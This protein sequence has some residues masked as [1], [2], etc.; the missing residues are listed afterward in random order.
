MKSTGV[1]RRVDELGRIVIPK[2]IRNNMRI[3]SGEGLEIFT[4]ED[5]LILKKFSPI[6]S[7]EVLAQ[8]YVD[9]IYKT[10][11]HNIIVTDMSKVIALAG[12]LKKKYMNEEISDFVERSIERRDN[13]VERQKKNFKIIENSEEFGYY[14]F[15]S[16]V[17]NGDC[18]GS[19]IIVSLD[20]PLLEVE[21]KMAVV[22]SRL[23]EGSFVL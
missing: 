23:L 13:F 5:M 17:V 16:I 11:K 18:L 7:L 22:L 10:I 15:C 9:A 6:E 20:T 14:S 21:E 3:K 19:V 2:E 8:K 4:D 1:I 12:S